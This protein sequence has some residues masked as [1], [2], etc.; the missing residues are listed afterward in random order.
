M[1]VSPT[2]VWLAWEGSRNDVV[3]ALTIAP[4]AVQIIMAALLWFLAGMI[5]RKMVDGSPNSEQT[6]MTPFDWWGLGFALVG[7]F[8]IFS[9][10][11]ELVSAVVSK[12][13]GIAALI[14]GL[15]KMSLGIYLV[16]G[17]KG[18]VGLLIRTREFGRK[19]EGT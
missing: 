1:T 9:S 4:L 2:V 17:W 10:L 18:L 15:L 14:S 3:L 11:P 12:D 7:L 8:A 19:P 16:L 13:Y 6:K 5:S